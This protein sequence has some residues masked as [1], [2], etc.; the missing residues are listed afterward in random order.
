MGLES[1]VH[2]ALANIPV[3]KKV[4]KRSYQGLSV[5][6]SRPRKSEGKIKRVTPNDEYEYLFGYYDKSPWDASGRYILCIRVKDASREVAPKS[7]AEIVLIDTE[8]DNSVKVI[9]KTHT[10]NVQQ[11]CMAG[12]LGP[13]FNKE[14]FY[15]DCRHGKYCGVILNI[16]TGKEQVLDMPVYMVS[17]DGKIALSLD[18]SRLH[19]LRPGYG[20]SNLEDK[21]EG[22]K[23]PEGACVWKTD[24]KTGKAFPVLTY[25]QLF[26]FEHRD[27]MEG[28]EH[29]VNHL[30]LSPDGKRFMVIHRWLKGGKKIS[31]LLTC[32]IDGSDL[33]NLS[34]DNMVSHCCWRNNKEIL[35]YCQKGKKKGYFL[36]KDK[37]RDYAQKWEWLTAD[38]HP[39]YSPNGKLVVTDT[40]PNRKRLSTIRVLSDTASTMVA[41]VY[42]PFKYDNDT[43][44]DLHPRWSRDGKK[45]CFDGCF[46]GKREVY[47]VDVRRIAVESKMGQ[48]VKKSGKYKILFVLNSCKNRGPTRVVYNIIKN[49]DYAKF[50]PILLTL[51]E[52]NEESN[53]SEILPYVSSYTC[54]KTSKKD[55]LSGKM[56]RLK[57][58]LKDI[59]PAVIHTTGVFPD[60][61]ISKI[62]RQNQVVTLHNYASFDYVSKFGKIKGEL[63]VKMQY[64]A[65]RYA[66]KTVACSK[67]LSELYKKDG[68]NFDYIRNGIDV[69][70]Y[71]V[72]N[73][74][75]SLRKKLGLK[76]DAFIFIYTGSFVP[77]K[78]IEYTLKGF[79]KTYGDKSDI[80]FVL[81][82]DG[83][84]LER[85]RDEYAC[86]DNII[87]KGRMLNVNE[88]LSVSDVYISAS[89]SE[90]L[91]NGV[92]EAI[93]SG[94]PVLLSDIPQHEEILES[95]G[96]CGYA[97]PL[98]DTKQLVDLIRKAVNDGNLKRLSLNARKTA[99]DC[100]S[101]S[102][103]SKKYQNIYEEIARGV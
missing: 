24:L 101:G 58:A 41:K 65:A 1:K 2:D 43:R 102:M 66:A 45:I 86:Y 51:S 49:L 88:Y 74:K 39:S 20:Y 38:G 50:N 91:P 23:V 5:A 81:L 3:V 31:R 17:N 71:M 34:D 82:G 56:D 48:K 54:C 32:N 85:L 93:A 87:F 61:A 7:I 99:E 6:M 103:M 53:I 12:W 21:T 28:A 22:E 90:G 62:S 30:M 95:G 73:N 26:E 64:C 11:G 16:K 52:E 33:Y 83:P 47:V 84:E 19:R 36:M 80:L 76:K 46:E 92:L 60:Y 27:D 25:K 37:T 59:G 70:K 96:E 100:F 63:L 40:Y 67:S 94:L 9:A 68:F 10:W 35:A 55:I 8:N 97:F 78:N 69:E 89:K 98:D 72:R 44:C 18:F 14:I 4:V 77:G 75:N 79:T 15:N 29:K 13:D 57:K 42:S